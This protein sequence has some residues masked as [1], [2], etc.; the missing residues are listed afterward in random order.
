[1]RSTPRQAALRWEKDN[2]PGAWKTWT[3]SQYLSDS[4]QVGVQMRMQL[5]VISFFSLFHA[6]F[7]EAHF[8]MPFNTPHVFSRR[9]A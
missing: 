1:M 5:F 8:G 2:V 7:I 9:I 4:M 6:D 3:W